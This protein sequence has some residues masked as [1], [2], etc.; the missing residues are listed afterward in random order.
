M[1][2]TLQCFSHTEILTNYFLNENNTNKI[3]NNNIARTNP[4]SLQLSPSYL[5]LIKNLWNTKHKY[6]PPTSFRKRLAE[7]NP[8]FKE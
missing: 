3:Y 5:E 8:L 4:E 1:N 7:M 2:A 6:Y